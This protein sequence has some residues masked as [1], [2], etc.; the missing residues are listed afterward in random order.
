MSIEN[1]QKLVTNINRVI[2]GK[3]DQIK[4]AVATLLARGHL[5]L[6]DIP[7]VGKTTLA[8]A[9]AQSI[10]CEFQRIQATSDLLPSDVIG[11]SIYDHTKG[12]FDFK[13]GPIFTNLLLVDE[14]NRATPRTQSSLL[15]AMNEFAVSI[16]QVTH[17]L[18]P[19][20]FVIATQNP[21]EQIGTYLL[22]E[23]QLDRFTARIALGYPTIESEER[24]IFDQ[25]LEHPL[26]WRCREDPVHPRRAGAPGDPG[27]R[28]RGRLLHGSEPGLRRG[29]RDHGAVLSLHGPRPHRVQGPELARGAPGGGER[30]G[31]VPLPDHPGQR[32]GVDA[33]PA[34]GGAPVRPGAAG[35]DH[36][37]VRDR[38]QR[39]AQPQGRDVSAHARLL[40]RPRPGRPVGLPGRAARPG[41]DPA[42]AL[43]GGGRSGA[44]QAPVSDHPGVQ[45]AG[46]LDRERLQHQ[47]RGHRLLRPEGV[48]AGRPDQQ[49]PLEGHGQ[50]RQAAGDRDRRGPGQPLLRVRRSE[51]VQEDRRGPAVQP[52]GVDPDRRHPD[53]PALEAQLP[54]PGLPPGR[55]P[56]QL[57]PELHGPRHP[58]GH[59]VPRPDRLHRGG[60]LPAGRGEGTAGGAAGIV[61][62]VRA[63]RHRPGDA[64][65]REEPAPFAVLAL[66]PVQPARRGGGPSGLQGPDRPGDRQE[67]RLHRLLRRLRGAGG[68]AV[69]AFKRLWSRLVSEEAGE[70]GGMY[71]EEAARIRG[72]DSLSWTLIL[73]GFVPLAWYKLS[74]APIWIALVAACWTARRRALWVKTEQANRLAA[75]AMIGGMLFFVLTGD[76]LWAFSLFL[77]LIGAVLILKSDM[78]SEVQ[79]L[80]LVCFVLFLVFAH[81]TL[82]YSFLLGLFLLLM[83]GMLVMIRYHFPEEIRPGRYLATARLLLRPVLVSM[84]VAAPIFVICPRIPVAVLNVQAPPHTAGF[85]DEIRFGGMRS[86][87]ESDRL[88]MTIRAERG[89]KWRG[90]TLDYYTGS[91]WK[92]TGKIP[93]SYEAGD[94]PT[95]S[96]N[97]PPGT[98]ILL[99]DRENRGTIDLAKLDR[100]E[101]ILEPTDVRQFFAPQFP[102]GIDTE[103]GSVE[104]DKA[105]IL[106]RQEDPQA[107][108]IRY[109]VW[110]GKALP[111]EGP[112]Q[113]SQMYL[114]LPPQLP[115]RVADLARRVTAGATTDRQKAERLEKFLADGDYTYTLST[116]TPPN[117]DSV[118]HFLFDAKAGHCEYFASAMALML[119]TVR[120]PSRVVVGFNPGLLNPYS[121]TWSVLERNAHAWVEVYL[122]RDDGWVEFDPTTG[123]GQEEVVGLAKRLGLTNFRAWVAL[124]GLLNRLDFEW[125]TWVVSF[126]V[127]MQSSLLHAIY[128]F[129]MDAEIAIREWWNRQRV[130]GL[131]GMLAGLAVLLAALYK[132]SPRIRRALQKLW[133]LLATLLAWLRKVLRRIGRT[134]AYPPEEAFYHDLLRILEGTNLVKRGSET[135]REFQRRIAEKLPSLA[136]PAGVITESYYQIAYRGVQLTAGERSGIALAIDQVRQRL[137]TAPRT[138]TQA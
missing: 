134:A 12:T 23:C 108:R 72:G 124:M 92:R 15:Q 4:V 128:Q 21:V 110:W 6:E 51:R 42:G 62:A 28:L 30:G 3:D 45:P 93:R 90:T 56:D 20:F 82:D 121:G 106:T 39:A 103:F 133:A 126:S 41:G 38:P 77:I 116:V 68:V 137:V 130:K 104:C 138:P 135:P 44:A 53:A 132:L 22:P 49:D 24:M 85:G 31:P 112:V 75:C 11:V 111:M 36:P 27:G 95:Q 97:G 79:R 34:Q 125:Q 8:R 10:Q 29:F 32:V 102:L 1:V 2:L 78:E 50:A 67:R 89:V 48:R 19:L 88:F 61:P 84:V 70:R 118:D 64:G 127:S 5:L 87:L 40:R 71:R 57:P 65:H 43:R 81:L 7:G 131:L 16:D 115:A 26:E 63:A 113:L 14:I 73:T 129:F 109:V 91:G 100:A 96:Y 9:L 123:R 122:G 107:K 25:M 69:N 35:K 58:S 66:L 94:R 105:R 17:K 46:G 74:L 86:T 55:R 83:S 54:G 47:G 52:G 80:Y 120:V 76:R 114:R 33:P 13:R 37:G 136:D 60:G 99:T 18:G 117:R 98:P 59:E 101:V 119:R